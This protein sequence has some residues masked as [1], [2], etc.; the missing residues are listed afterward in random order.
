MRLLSWRFS[1]SGPIRMPAD[2]ACWASRRWASTALSRA[3]S[4][5]ASMSRWTAENDGPHGD[6][7]T[8][9]AASA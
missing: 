9:P 3:S 4:D 2:L 6:T 8:V 1:V 5:G 7:D